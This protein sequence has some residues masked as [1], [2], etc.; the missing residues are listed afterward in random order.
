MAVTPKF[1][2][3]E[4]VR[5]LLRLGFTSRKQMG[6]R[7]VKYNPPSNIKLKPGQRSF[8]MVQ[9]NIK[10]YDSNAC[11]RYI[12]EIKAFGFSREEVIRALTK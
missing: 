8:I 5:C 2:S 6:T 1:G 4:L 12:N 9:E 7:H 3:R 11:S 10:T